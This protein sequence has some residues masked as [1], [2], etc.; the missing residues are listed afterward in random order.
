MTA[1]LSCPKCGANFPLAAVAATRAEPHVLEIIALDDGR[2]RLVMD[3]VFKRNEAVR[4]LEA[5]QS[6]D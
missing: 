3:L 1:I 2:V 6:L 5:A 4:V